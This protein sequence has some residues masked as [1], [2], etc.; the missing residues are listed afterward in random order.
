MAYGGAGR[1]SAAQAGRGR[2]RRGERRKKHLLSNG[3]WISTPSC[4]HTGMR[5]RP[6]GKRG[7]VLPC[8]ADRESKTR[9]RVAVAVELILQFQ[10]HLPLVPKCLV[11]AST[12]TFA[13]SI[14]IRKK[15]RSNRV[16]LFNRS[17]VAVRSCYIGGGIRIRV[18]RGGS[19]EGKLADAQLGE[20][21]R[22]EFD[23][24]G[25]AAAG[26]CCAGAHG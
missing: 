3:F 13:V 5:R 21:V 23:V 14:E 2:A 24:G 20:P 8:C 9:R 16:A 25:L 7:G 12:S 18:S 1:G 10:L 11:R 17:R 6:H 15:W 22:H 26:C 19:G 4:R